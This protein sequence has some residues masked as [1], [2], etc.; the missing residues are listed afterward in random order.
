MTTYAE[1]V[2]QQYQGAPLE[3]VYSLIRQKVA[4]VFP[5][6]FTPQDTTKTTTTKVAKP[7][8]PSSPVEA[9]TNNGPTATFTSANLT[10]DQTAIMNQFVKTGVMTEK[11]YIKDIANMQEA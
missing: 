1:S 5:D 3:R 11:Q 7:V 10:P 8:G 2:A 4:E 9:P 6:K